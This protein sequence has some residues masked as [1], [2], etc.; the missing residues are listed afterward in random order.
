MG[1]TLLKMMVPMNYVLNTKSDLPFD[2][3]D[4]PIKQHHNM[5]AAVDWGVVPGHSL[6]MLQSLI[7]D[8]YIPMTETESI[9]QA[10]STFSV[11]S[12]Y[13]FRYGCTFSTNF[14]PCRQ[15]LTLRLP[16]LLPRPQMEEMRQIWFVLLTGNFLDI[17]VSLPK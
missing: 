6:V 13:V 15:V 9:H 2:L 17:S 16:W 12:L 8:I 3:L 14:S 7:N 5:V 1:S 11:E 4:N 10:C